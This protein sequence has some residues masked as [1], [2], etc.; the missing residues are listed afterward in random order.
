MLVV[1]EAVTIGQ[2][3]PQECWS[4]EGHH[5]GLPHP[6]LQLL[7]RE[8]HCS[9]YRCPSVWET[10]LYKLHLT[11]SSILKMVLKI[12]YNKILFH[13]VV[14]CCCFPSLQNSFPTSI[15]TSGG[16]SDLKSIHRNVN[17]RGLSGGGRERIYELFETGFSLNSPSSCLSLVL[18]SGITNQC[19]HIWL[20]I[21]FPLKMRQLSWVVRRSLYVYSCHLLHWSLLDYY[22]DLIT[23]VLRY[24]IFV[25]ISETLENEV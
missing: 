15:P 3:M 5:S 7:K 17:E 9:N 19:H 10:K 8:H 18:N 22:V 14:L 25:V 1:K 11:I 20:Q 6:S 4:K 16:L 21:R 23:S 24:K 12:K 13:R 2:P